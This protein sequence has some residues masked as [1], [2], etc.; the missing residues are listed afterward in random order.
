MSRP[1]FFHFSVAACTFAV[2]VPALYPLAHAEEP[3][4]KATPAAPVFAD[5]AP[6]LNRACVP[7][8]RTGEVAPF[9]L[10]TYAQAKRWAAMIADST[11]RGAMPPW[12][13][14]KGFGE[15]HDERNLTGEERTTLAA[16]AKAGAPAG[17]LTKAPTAPNTPVLEWPAGTPDLTVSADAPYTLAPEG[18]DEYRCFVLPTQ[19]AQDAYVTLSQ[20]KPGNR[21]VV[22]H[23]IL[24]A[25]PTGTTAV[26]ADNADPRPGF[27][28]PHAGGGPP[29]PG[30]RPVAAWAPGSRAKPMPPGVAAKIPKGARLILEV[31]YHHTGKTEIDQTRVGLTFARDTVNQLAGG[32][33]AAQPFLNL[34]AGNAHIPVKSRVTI[35]EDVHALAVAPHMHLTGKEMHLWAEKPTGEKVE[36]IWVKN[37]DFNWQDAYW[38]RA[39]IALPQGTTVFMEAAFDNSASNPRN[40]HTP[41]QTLHW[42]EST[43]DEMCLALLAVTRDNERRGITPPPWR[44][45]IR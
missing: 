25:D 44:E 15:F 1:L 7:C 5:V 34:P 31:H 36:L 42:G 10:G 8:H 19:F 18:K 9:A 22:H 23:V 3:S 21:A 12:K 38:F 41:P 4:K 28:N 29:T 33:A 13:A 16:W 37:W 24:Y 2:A 43:T 11:G 27:E 32:Y 35:K 6:I 40:P 39:P 20:V 17:D 30:A 45:A 26:Q 14:V